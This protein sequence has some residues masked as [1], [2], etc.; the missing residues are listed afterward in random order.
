MTL[1][2]ILIYL[3]IMVFATG[4]STHSFAAQKEPVRIEGLS[5]HWMPKRVTEL[6]DTGKV[7]A[8]FTTSY[9][10]NGR[11]VYECDCPTPKDL[12]SYFKSFPVSFQENGVWL[13][14]THPDAYSP[15]ELKMKDEL[16]ALCQKEKIPLFI[17]RGSELPDGWKKY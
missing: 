11:Y 15:E 4:L 9:V 1:K 14:T 10:K 3:V 2:K 13:V 8:G 6:D 17:C 7:K 12:I 5:A 16:I